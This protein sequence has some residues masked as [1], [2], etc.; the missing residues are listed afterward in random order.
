VD[1]IIKVE[2]STPPVPKEEVQIEK[3]N[4]VPPSPM[5]AWFRGM[6]KL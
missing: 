2:E 3:P 6:F 1:N 5:D 4:E